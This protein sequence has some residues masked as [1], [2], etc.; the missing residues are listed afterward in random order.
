MCGDP[1]DGA[2]LSVVSHPHEFGLYWEV[3][4]DFDPGSRAAYEYAARC[5]TSAPPTWAAAV[6]PTGSDIVDARRQRSERTGFGSSSSPPFSA[7]STSHWPHRFTRPVCS[8]K[9]DRLTY[10][11]RG[12]RLLTGSS[13]ADLPSYGRILLPESGRPWN[14]S[15]FP[16]APYW[17]P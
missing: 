16:A 12:L 1:P 13:F 7:I 5:D 3:V 10:L 14:R 8:V 11:N 15:P 2:R 17:R 9:G 4:V 6:K